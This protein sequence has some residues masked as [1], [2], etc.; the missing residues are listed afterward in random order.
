MERKFLTPK[1]GPLSGIRVLGAGS[2]VAMPSA[3]NMLA[4]LGAEFIHIERP[5]KGD[6]TT[7]TLSDI[8]HQEARNRLSLTLDLIYINLK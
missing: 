4:D 2:A 3:A 8:W 5:G 7:R 1:F 6:V